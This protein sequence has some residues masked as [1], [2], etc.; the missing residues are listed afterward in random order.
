MVFRYVHRRAEYVFYND[1]K[2][3]FLFVDHIVLECMLDDLVF[4]MFFDCHASGGSWYD[5]SG[6]P[7]AGN[8]YAFCLDTHWHDLSDFTRC[9]IFLIVF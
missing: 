4:T 6:L 7:G 8:I 1:L 9:C 2:L 3:E 5:I